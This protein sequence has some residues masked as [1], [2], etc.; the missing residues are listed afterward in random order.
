MR[1]TQDGPKRWYGL[2][3]S[4]PAKATIM[5]EV[6]SMRKPIASSAASMQDTLN[7]VAAVGP[8]ELDTS[9]RRFARTTKVPAKRMLKFHRIS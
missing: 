9:T 6:W 5:L 3:V 2:P 8:L 1:W 7:G 4:A